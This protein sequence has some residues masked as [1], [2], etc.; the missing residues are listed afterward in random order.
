MVPRLGRSLILQEALLLAVP[1]IRLSTWL[2]SDCFR[3]MKKKM[4]GRYVGVELGC[5]GRKI[6]GLEGV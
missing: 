3:T 2:R 4:P 1:S 5:F 6:I